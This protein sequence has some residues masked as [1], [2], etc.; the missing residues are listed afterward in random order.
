[1]TA[2][3]TSTNFESSRPANLSTSKPGIVFV[4]NAIHFPERM[5][6][7]F[8]DEF[9]DFSFIRVQHF[10]ELRSIRSE[11][12]DVCLIILEEEFAEMLLAQAK[13]LLKSIGNA[14]V[15]LAFSDPKVAARLLPNASELPDW[16]G[17]LPLNAQLEVWLSVMRLLLCGFN[18]VPQDVFDAGRKAVRRMVE[19]GRSD[20]DLTPREW[21]VLELVADGLQNKIIAAQLSLSEHTIKLHI[22]NL[23]KK[24]GVSNRTCAANWFQHLA[25]PGSN[26]TGS[27][28]V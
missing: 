16:I 10:S 25:S 17:Y 2:I 9:E 6:K 11:F 8:R 1:M 7:I 19:P 27:A 14:Q 18:A 28:G 26:N 22:H 21:Q 24:I 20:V 4:G 15:A 13:P 3:S 23:L 12:S 5:L